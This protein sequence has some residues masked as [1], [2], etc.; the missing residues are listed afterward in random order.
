MSLAIVSN[1][2]HLG[3]SI[4]AQRRSALTSPVKL[5]HVRFGLAAVI[6]VGVSAPSTAKSG[7]APP[8]VSFEPYLRFLFNAE[9]VG[10]NEVEVTAR[11]NNVSERL[12]RKAAQ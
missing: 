3:H 1:V 5:C 8:Q 4:V 11:E 6:H 7:A 2:P 12:G 9:N 10:F